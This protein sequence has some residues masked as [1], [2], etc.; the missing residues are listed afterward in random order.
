VWVLNFVTLR[1]EHRLRMF[2][3][4]ILRRIFVPK[5][6]EVAEG[7]T[8]GSFVT[9]TFH[10]MLLG[11]QIKVGEI[12]GSCSTRQMGNAYK[13][14]SGNLKGRDHSEDLG[15]DGKIILELILEK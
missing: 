11:D 3:N 9:C 5:R 7:C 6:G 8:L 10:Q 12:G 13:F 15:I 1:E 2:E 4:R 14:W